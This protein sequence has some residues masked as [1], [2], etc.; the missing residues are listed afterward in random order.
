MRL[1]SGMVFSGIF[2][3]TA[4]STTIFLLIGRMKTDV[5]LMRTT[6]LSQVVMFRGL[7]LISMRLV[8]QVICTTMKYQCVF[9]ALDNS[10]SLL[11]FYALIL[12]EHMFLFNVFVAVSYLRRR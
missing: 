7:F 1:S 8:Y 11:L 9:C 10:A 4:S 12:I 3:L 6:S 5:S 2:Y